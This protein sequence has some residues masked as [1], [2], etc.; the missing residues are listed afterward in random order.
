MGYI[1]EV[2]L[3]IYNLDTI[4]ILYSDHYISLSKYVFICVS[5]PYRQW[6]VLYIIKTLNNL[7]FEIY[8]LSLTIVLASNQKY[9][10]TGKKI[11][12]VLV[13][14]VHIFWLAPTKNFGKTMECKVR[15][16]RWCSFPES[17]V[18]ECKFYS[19]RGHR[20]WWCQGTKNLVQELG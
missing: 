14:V 6:I 4:H 19:W 18:C 12:F 15:C 16:R 7:V 9:E 20:R 5:E 3:S 13:R 11:H 1:R 8:K 10:K 2:E 17:V